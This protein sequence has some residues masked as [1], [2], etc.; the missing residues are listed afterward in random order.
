MTWLIYS[1]IV[2]L[3]TALMDFFIKLSSGKIHDGIGAIIIGIASVI[4]I[5]AATLFDKAAGREIV[6]TKMGLI[7]SF[8]AGVS[9]G[10]ATLFI[11]KIF[12]TG[13]NISVSVAVFRSAVI[14][15]AG[16]LGVVFLKESINLQM[17]LGFILTIIGVILIINSRF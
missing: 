1:L 4:P 10:F 14:L 9:I 12:N 11:F 13:V 6:I 16:L 2:A 3:S 7:Y 15:F 17:G 8:I 5:T